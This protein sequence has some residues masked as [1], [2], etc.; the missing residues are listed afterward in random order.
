[1]IL[2]RMQDKYIEYAGFTPRKESDVMIRLKVLAG[3]IYKARVY[4]DYVLRQ[5]FL[6]TAEGAYLDGHAAERGITRRPAS[7]ARGT[8]L[9]YPSEENHGSILIP[10]GTV[11]CSSADMCRYVSD[12]DV[13]LAAGEPYA[14]VNVTAVAD[15]AAYNGNAGTIDIIVTPVPGIGRIY[16]GSQITGG[17]DE[18]SDDELRARVQDSYVHITNGVNAAYYKNLA[19]SVRGVKSAAV[20]GNSRGAGTVDVYV[21]GSGMTVSTPKLAEVQALLSEKRELNVDVRARHPQPVYVSL[22]IRLKVEPGYD[23]N[24]VAAEVQTKVTDF[25]DLLGVGRDLLLSEVG[26]LIYH[27]EGV[28]DY[29]FLESYGGDCLIEA[30]QYITSDNIVVREV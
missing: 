22:Y 4:A 30:S 27:I 10:A 19:L 16:N 9:F 6:S 14:W 26:E 8:V 15:G 13:V 3:E 24:T 21:L 29:R 1:M 20:V 2:K 5:M 25:V 18:E 17:A 12:E 23:F 11:L 7:K 28:R